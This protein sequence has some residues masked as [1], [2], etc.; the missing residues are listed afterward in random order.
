MIKFY[1]NIRKKLLNEG[2]T[3]KYLKYAIGEIVLVVIGILIALQINNWNE[4]RLKNIEVKTYL[5]NLIEDLKDDQDKMNSMYDW[6]IFKFYS[7][8]YLLKIEGSNPYNPFTDNKN[9]IPPYSKTRFWD[10]EIPNTYNK[11]FIQLTFSKTHNE[12]M[13]ASTN[14]TLVELKSTGIYSNISTDLKDEINYYYDIYANN[15]NGKVQIL[16]RNWQAS[17]AEDGYLTTDTYK[18]QDP[19]SL[20]K[21]NPNRIGL[22]KRMIRESGW[23][24]QTIV[25]LKKLNSELIMS[26]EKEINSL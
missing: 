23:T 26:L 24:L 12:Q 18:L 4:N 21:D 9:D 5:M 7:M 6:H 13:I 15:F 3:G 10:A 17:L 14:S 1:R 11:D 8:Q 16:A 22:M 25:M 20:L 19:I 2:S